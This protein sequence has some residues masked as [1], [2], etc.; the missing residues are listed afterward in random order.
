MMMIMV[1][2]RGGEAIGSGADDPQ[3]E[4]PVV[5]IHPGHVIAPPF[6]PP[7]AKL[8][9]TCILRLDPSIPTCPTCLNPLFPTFLIHTYI[10]RLDPPP[11]DHL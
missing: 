8:L 7:P 5:G 1:I 10:Q 6:F 4:G 3:G 11:P 2:I 9:F